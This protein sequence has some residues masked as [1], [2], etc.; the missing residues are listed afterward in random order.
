MSVAPVSGLLYGAHVRANGI[1]QHYLRFGGAGPAIVIVPGIS[2]TAAQWAFIAERLCV[3]YDV[4]VL[5]VR[6]RGLS[7]SGPHLNYSLDACASDLISFAEALEIGAYTLLGHSMG[8]RIGI[9]AARWRPSSM[10]QL[11]LVDPPVSGPGRR[12]YPSPIG[13]LLKLLHSASLGEA[14]AVL[15]SPSAP[16]WPER[17]IRARAEWMHTCD[18]RALIESHKGFHHDDIH[19][20]LANLSVRTWLLVAGKGDVIRPEDEREIQRLLPS[21]EIKRLESAGHQMHIDDTEGFLSIV[22]DVLA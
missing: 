2:T 13:P 17:H 19:N 11:I 7:E 6:G 4:Y 14:D 16:R 18:E 3:G 10:R 9:R 8:A 21:I 12:A 5:D 1:R 15:R 22:S 20:D